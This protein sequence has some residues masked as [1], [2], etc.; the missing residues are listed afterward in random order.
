MGLVV[1]DVTDKGVPAALV[2]AATRSVLRAAAQRLT[3]PARCW[4]GSTSALCPTSRRNMFVTCLYG[5]LDPSSGRLALRQR[6]PQPAVSS[7]AAGAPSELR[8]TGM[9]LGL[10]PGHGLRG[11]RDGAG[12]RATSV[13]FY[14]DGLVEAHDPTATCSASPR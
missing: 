4:S 8:A 14:S 9:P 13:L 10:M 5:V 11:A 6:R 12:A 3:R 2:M 7:A 1:G